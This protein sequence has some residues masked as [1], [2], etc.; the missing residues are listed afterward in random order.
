V[1]WKSRRFRLGEQDCSEINGQRNIFCLAVTHFNG[2]F[3]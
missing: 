2:L 1:T 3:V